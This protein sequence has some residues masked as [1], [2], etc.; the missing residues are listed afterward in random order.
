MD[1][2]AIVFSAQLYDGYQVDDWKLQFTREIRRFT[3]IAHIGEYV[4]LPLLLIFRIS[5]NGISLLMPEKIDATNRQQMEAE[6]LRTPHCVWK[7]TIVPASFYTDVLH[8]FLDGVKSRKAPILIYFAHVRNLKLQY[9]MS[10]FSMK[11][12]M[13]WSEFQRRRNMT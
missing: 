5:I 10:N 6:R 13:I 7:Q 9:S 12:S 8:P 11:N 4:T 2:A 3:N 1:P